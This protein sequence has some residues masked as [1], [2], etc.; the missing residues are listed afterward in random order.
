M[1]SP[2]PALVVFVII[3]PAA[4]TAIYH[5]ISYKRGWD[6]DDFDIAVGDGA[7]DCDSECSGCFYESIDEAHFRR[8]ERW[9]YYCRMLQVRTK[10][11]SKERFSESI[12]SIF[13]WRRKK[14]RRETRFWP[15][16]V[17]PALKEIT[18]STGPSKRRT[19]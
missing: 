2:I 4:C 18:W 9:R 14:K 19:Q 17:S 10:G 5:Y 1:A 13:R 3:L 7:D 16:R 11:E 8:R 12:E 6:V 15:Q